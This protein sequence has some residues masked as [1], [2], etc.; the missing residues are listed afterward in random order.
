[1][2]ARNAANAYS[3][4]G[5]QTAA[6]NASPHRLIAML[7]D[8]ARTAIARAR[9]HMEAGQVP[10]KGLAISKAIDII[11]NGLSA[12]LDHGASEELAGNL[13]ALYD[14]MA[15][16]LMLANLNNDDARLSEVDKL[17]GDLASAWS[18]VDPD[19]EAQAEPQTALPRDAVL[20]GA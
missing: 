1:M 6:M 2:Y 15:R 10:E 3:N 14:Y 9:F 12:A 11:E 4:V 13:D 19:R 8:G 18:Q 16:Q 7:F 17:L 20:I 5:L